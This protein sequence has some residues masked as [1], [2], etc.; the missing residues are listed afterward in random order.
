[1]RKHFFLSMVLLTVLVVLGAQNPD[2]NPWFT[3]NSINVNSFKTASLDPTA[4]WNQPILTNLVISNHSDAAFRFYLKLDIY[5]SGISDPLASIIYISKETI[6]ALGQFYPLTNQDLVTN[7]PS[8]L[9]DRLGNNAFSLDDITNRSSVLRQAALAGY[10]PDGVLSLIVKVQPESSGSQDWNGASEATFTIWIVNAEAISLISPGT[11][12]SSSPPVVDQ[13]PV[14]FVWNSIDTNINVYKLTIREYPNNLPPD[15]N[16]LADTGSLFYDQHVYGNQFTEFLPFNQGS[17]YAWRISTKRWTE[18]DS[19]V[20]PGPWR[21]DDPGLISSGW[22]I[23]RYSLFESGADPI[24]R[25]C[26]VLN[27]LGEDKLE[28]LF[29]EGFRPTGE[30]IWNGRS[31]SGQSAID[32]IEQLLGQR[33][34]ITVWE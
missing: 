32:L 11:P 8:T 4:P 24:H 7:Q 30:I 20:S 2:V 13:T 34:V 29:N 3:P 27:S 28:A 23:F 22:N 18:L 16:S 19:Y 9:F 1:M 33:A 25:I 26:A 21:E 15:I 10:F 17:Y 31:Y 14:N 5:W 12:A 6:P